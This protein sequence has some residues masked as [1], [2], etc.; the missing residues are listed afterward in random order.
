MKFSLYSIKGKQQNEEKEMEVIK[1]K[2]ST[3]VQQYTATG[4][5]IAEYETITQAA[6]ETGITTTSITNALWWKENRTA[7]GFIWTVVGEDVNAIV[8][9]NKADAEKRLR[10]KKM[11]RVK[12]HGR[13]KEKRVEIDWRV[14]RIKD[15]IFIEKKNL[16]GSDLCLRCSINANGDECLPCRKEERKDGKQGYWRYSKPVNA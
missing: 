7:K 9:K 4:E 3:R 13:K 1:R 12:G 16:C 11:S 2:N 6:R 15:Y 5:F 14:E 8:E 10:D